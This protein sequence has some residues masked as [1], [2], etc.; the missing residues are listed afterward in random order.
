MNSRNHQ[1]IADQAD[2]ALQA[3]VRAQ[4]EVP[5][6]R[7]REIIR[8]GGVQ[9]A[10]NVVTDPGFRL[11]VGDSIEAN[12]EPMRIRTAQRKMLSKG[13]SVLHQDRHVIVVNKPSGL[14]TVPTDDDEQEI[15]LLGEISRKLRSEGEKRPPLFVIQRLDRNTSGVLVI[16]RTPDARDSLKRQLKSRK[17]ERRYL[18]ICQGITPTA[19][20]TCMFPLW[21]DPRSLKVHICRKDEQG[22]EAITR[23]KKLD[24]KDN[25]SLME[26]RL[27]TGRRNQI[28]VHLGSIKLPIIGDSRY[29][30]TSPFIQRPA[31][32]AETLSFQHPKSMEPLSYQVDAPE[33]FSGALTALGL[34]L[35]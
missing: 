13:L 10:G 31:L 2:R 9:V 11:K 1:W 27:E 17:V 21:E 22:L 19:E 26:A 8:R 34:S 3:E 12:S 20:G 15:C 29:G 6:R 32:H 23:W 7:A 16:A 4:L 28:R 35:A 14:L 30:V 33:D 5:H 24:A 25:H 18:A